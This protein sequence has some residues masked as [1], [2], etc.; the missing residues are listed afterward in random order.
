MFR[1]HL[2]CFW[3]FP[4]F[5][6]KPN[7]ICDSARLANPHIEPAATEPLPAPA[8]TTLLIRNPLFQAKQAQRFDRLMMMRQAEQRHIVIQLTL[9]AMSEFAKGE[10]F[11]AGSPT[12]LCEEVGN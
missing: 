2:H 7:E 11:V 12:R 1:R 5:A 10:R 9:R 4:V 3:D 8:G 6:A